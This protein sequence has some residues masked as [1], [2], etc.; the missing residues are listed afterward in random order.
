[1]SRSPVNFLRAR[2]S[3]SRARSSFSVFVRASMHL[4]WMSFGS[5]TWHPR[6]TTSRRLSS[7]PYC[8][9]RFIQA[10]KTFAFSCSSRKLMELAAR[11]ASF[12]AAS[13][14]AK[15]KR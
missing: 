6:L 7:S 13:T 11:A 5:Q 14:S 1:M 12:R 10:A 4:R 3:I 15:D 2:L 9:S 8:S